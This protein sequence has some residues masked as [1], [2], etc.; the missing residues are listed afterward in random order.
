MLDA[1]DEFRAATFNA[2]HGF[3]RQS[4][5]CARNVLELVTVGSTCQTL[6]LHSRFK[7]WRDGLAEFAFG[8]ACDLLIG[9]ESLRGLRK[10]IRRMTAS[11]ITELA[12]LVNGDISRQRSEPFPCVLINEIAR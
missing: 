1:A 11:S 10:L 8:A 9:A 6:K 3:Y 12:T 5:G 7:Y 4:I 2:L